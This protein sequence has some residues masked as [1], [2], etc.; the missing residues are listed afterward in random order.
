[1]RATRLCAAIAISIAVSSMAAAG[2]DDRPV[3]MLHVH[4]RAGVTPDDFARAQREV[5]RIFEDAGVRI[6]WVDAGTAAGGDSVTTPLPRR[7]ILWLVN[8]ER[9]SKA[10]ASGCALGLAVGSTSTT[11]VFVNRVAAATRDRPVDRPIFIGHAIAHEVG[12]VLLPPGRHSRY[13]LMRGDLD[14]SVTNPARF[15]REE[16]EALRRG[17]AARSTGSINARQS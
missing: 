8:I 11:Y 9:D 15:T 3:V 1:M 13:G 10:G 7:V 17:L 16:I 6:T 5:E 2:A 14:F 4:N 12:H